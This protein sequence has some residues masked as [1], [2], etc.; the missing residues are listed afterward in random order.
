MKFGGLPFHEYVFSQ[1]LPAGIKLAA[2]GDAEL[3]RLALVA[4]AEKPEFT[5]LSAF[6][7]MSYAERLDP[8]A[9]Y[10]ASESRPVAIK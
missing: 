6:M 4:F 7:M 10:R 5:Q 9:V 8:G 3:Q 1:H 2:G